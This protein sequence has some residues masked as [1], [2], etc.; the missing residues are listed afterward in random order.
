MTNYMGKARLIKLF[1]HYISERTE[2]VKSIKAAVKEYGKETVFRYKKRR[3]IEWFDVV[4]HNGYS[5]YFC[6]F[7]QSSKTIYFEELRYDCE[8]DKW[9]L[10]NKIISYYSED[11]YPDPD[12]NVNKSLDCY[13]IA[14][15]APKNAETTIIYQSED[16]T[17][18]SFQKIRNDGSSDKTAKCKELKIALPDGFFVFS[19]ECGSKSIRYKNS[20]N[21][22]AIM[23][24]C[25]GEPYLYG[26]KRYHSAKITV[27]EEIN[28][29][30]GIMNEL[31]RGEKYNERK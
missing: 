12:D 4:H 3:G 5:F 21:E 16:G 23:Q 7:G 18:Y 6:V 8:S 22:Y 19:D 27:L 17:H 2:Y 31:K 9:E 20:T 25:K 10:L 11:F 24:N 29:E 14:K 1:Y 15:A 26:G 30:S 28:C 13:S